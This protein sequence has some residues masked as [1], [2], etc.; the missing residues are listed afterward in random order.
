MFSRDVVYGYGSLLIPLENVENHR[1][2]IELYTPIGSD[3]FNNWL[4]KLAGNPPTFKDP[5]FVSKCNDR[6]DIK[7]KRT[8][9]AQ[10]MLHV[11]CIGKDL[12][13]E[14]YIQLYDVTQTLQSILLIDQ[15][16]NLLLV[17]IPWYTHLSQIGIA[18]DFI[19]VILH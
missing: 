11:N 4:N 7:V 2:N 6:H 12:S 3:F 14:V 19:P 16:F 5:N 18:K 9:N 15:L 8:G 1:C 17:C 10:V 13:I